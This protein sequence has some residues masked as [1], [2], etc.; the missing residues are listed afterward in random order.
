M[1]IYEKCDALLFTVSLRIV[2]FSV[3]AHKVARKKRNGNEHGK[4]SN[5]A[6][7]NHI[8]VGYKVAIMR[9]K[10]ASW[11][12]F[13]VLFQIYRWPFDLHSLFL[14]QISISGCC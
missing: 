2:C 10:L 12:K 5:G 13:L 9:A 14:Q 6:I 3:I 7:C 8:P 4:S 1:T 11:M